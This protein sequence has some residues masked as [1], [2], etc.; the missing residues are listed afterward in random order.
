MDNGVQVWNK[1]LTT[2]L[3]LPGIKVNRTEFLK[4]ELSAYCPN[5]DIEKIENNRPYQLVG[6]DAVEK[7]AKACINNHTK[8]VTMTSAV[9]GIP[10]GWA[11]AASIPA[12]MVQF[13]GHVLTLSQ[14]LAYLY[15]FPDL[16]D[17]NGNLSTE[18]AKDSLTLFV[19]L[20]FGVDAAKKVINQMSQALAKESAKRIP[21]MALTKTAWYPIL[22]K[23]CSWLGIKI[24]KD[25][26]GKAAGKVI[27]VLGGLISGTLTYATFKPGAKR[28][29]KQLKES[30]KIFMAEGSEPHVSD[31]YVEV[32]EIKG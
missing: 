5:L 14:K 6:T 15:G 31:E 24:T 19:G 4:K 2:S 23:I 7:I 3:S 26:V 21:R 9:A 17:E 11:M 18:E 10:G 20:M 25:S 12:D 8:L 32:E 16:C 13:Y 27:P 29:Q 22:K 30:Q 1:I 28:L